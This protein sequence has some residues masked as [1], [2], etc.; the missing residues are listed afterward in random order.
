MAKRY[1]VETVPLDPVR[2]VPTIVDVPADGPVVIPGGGLLSEAIY[3]RHDNDLLIE[4]ADG[5]RMVVNGYFDL[6]SPPPL[7]SEAGAHVSADVI[8]ALAGDDIVPISPN[9]PVT[10]PIGRVEA[11]EG[12]VT[13]VRADGSRVDAEAGALIGRGDRV[14]T[15]AEGSAGFLFADEGTFSLG[16]SGRAIFEDLVFDPES[17]TAHAT[18]VVQQGTFSFAGVVSR[19]S[20]ARSRSRP[21]R[22][23]SMW[24]ARRVRAWWNVMVRPR[25]RIC[26][27]NSPTMAS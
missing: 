14:E 9:V 13:I 11:T 12:E 6:E 25:S 16:G 1:D 22:R 2:G 7:A 24:M 15:S 20:M 26:V 5:S 23:Q 8:S 10:A 18:F 21:H 27:T 17:A 3:A 19:P 4:L